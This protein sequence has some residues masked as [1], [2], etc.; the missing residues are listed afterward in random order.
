MTLLLS[1]EPARMERM[2]YVIEQY[3]FWNYQYLV[4]FNV[5][6]NIWINV[7]K[8]FIFLFPVGLEMLLWSRFFFNFAILKSNKGQ[9]K[10]VNAS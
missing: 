7:R 10:R 6:H 2:I 3:P 9:Y 4:E 1:S 5:P 8:N